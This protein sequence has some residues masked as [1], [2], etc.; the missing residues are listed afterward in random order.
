MI[1]CFYFLKTEKKGWFFTFAVLAS[2]VK[3][4]YLLSVAALGLYAMIRYKWYKTGLGLFMISMAIFLIHAKI[5]LPHYF[6]GINPMIQSKEGSHAYLGNSLTEILKTFFFNPLIIVKSLINLKKVLFVYVLF[7]PLLFIPIFSPWTLILSL[8]SF[9]IP[10]LSLELQHY[11]INNQYSASLIPFI[12]VSFVYGLERIVQNKNNIQQQITTK[13]LNIKRLKIIVVS[14]FVVTLHF[15]V[16]TSASPISCLFWGNKRDVNPYSF[17]NYIPT[18]RDIL[19]KKATRLIPEGMSVS[20]QNS[21]FTSQLAKRDIFFVFP[22]QY[23]FSDYIILDEKRLKYINNL[24]DVVIDSNTYDTLLK[25][26]P[27]THSIIFQ[28]DGIH[29]FKK[30]SPLPLSPNSHDFKF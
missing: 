24:I 14:V 4:P 23:K 25:E 28:K 10:L 29:L 19:L 5:I 6:E 1:S 27:E 9:A 30:H 3:E 11:A 8:P 7:A 16:V 20:A 22:E 18:K 21:V 2:M 12:F 15:N 17:K 13:G 26:I